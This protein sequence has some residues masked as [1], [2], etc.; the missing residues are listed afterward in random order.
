MIDPQLLRKDIASVEARLLARKFKLDVE[1]FNTLESERKSLQTRTE[2]LQAK[3]NQ[4]AKSIGMKK[5]KGEDAGAELAE[6]SQVNSDMESG[7]SRLSLLQAEIA[8]FLMGIPN[9]PD[10]SVPNGKDE[11][12][13]KEVKRW[14]QEPIFDFEIKDHVDLGAPLG[15]DFEVAA[16]ISGAR[17]AVLKGPIARLHRALA[18]FMLDTHS[19]QHG[20][21]EI[22]TPYMVNAASMRGTGQLP[23]FEE[24]LFKVPRKMGGAQSAEGGE[25]ERIENFYLI[26][27]AE[28]P[29]TNLV[30][31]EIVNADSLP[32]KYVAHTPCF[33]SEAG[34]YGRDVR[35]MI[36]Q[37][38]F[39]KVELVQIAKPQD[40]MQALEELTGHAEK[41]LELL[42]LPYRK[43]LLCTGDMG[44][45]ST[46]TYDLEVWVPS[47]KSYRE[48]SS[49]SNMGDFQARRMQA[50]FKDGQAKPE[51]VHTL[52]GSGLAVGRALVAL[53]ENKQQ[54]DG[55]IAIPKALQPYLGGLAV[56]KPI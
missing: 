50:R 6:A 18:Q 12:D 20:Y 55:S 28:V 1:K 32:M 41:I 47:Q 30:R 2:E 52:N 43:V 53:L 34:S 4:L 17:F 44:F 39:D 54:V 46:K 8:D 22:Y 29:V 19:T 13:N 27:T 31:D 38:Q 36:R 37:H 42:E 3:R 14:G 25:E 56:L 49:C 24:D 51:L 45:G 23:K 15:L 11:A 35:G 7:V 33:R 9:L 21:Q 10:E 26:P 48:I 40:S 5:G 16:K